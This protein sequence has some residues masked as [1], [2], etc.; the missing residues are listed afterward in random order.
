MSVRPG[1]RVPLACLALLTITGAVSAQTKVGIINLQKAV[2]ESAEIKKA[3]AAMT[4][5]PI[6]QSHRT[7]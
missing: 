4:E 5:L 2:L 3:S 1:L 7:T 6:V